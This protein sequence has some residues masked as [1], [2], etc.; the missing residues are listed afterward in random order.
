[1]NRSEIRKIG[2]NNIVDE[3]G[4][5][6]RAEYEQQQAEPLIGFGASIFDESGP[7][8]F[9]KNRLP[10]RTI[11]KEYQSHQRSLAGL[12]QD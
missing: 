10:E 2:G 9:A 3:H 7:S 11:E 4:Y 1:M 6:F 8:P 12:K 5:P